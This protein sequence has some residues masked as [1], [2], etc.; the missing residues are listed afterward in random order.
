MPFNI[1]N[2]NGLRGLVYV[3][4]EYCWHIPGNG[5]GQIGQLKSMYRLCHKQ[6]E[7]KGT[8]TRVALIL[9]SMLPP[10][11]G[12]HYSRHCGGGEGYHQRYVSVYAGVGRTA[13][14]MCSA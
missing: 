8:K 3:C 4:N 14:P 11:M 9:Y 13:S 6:I 1:N 12:I 5:I 7:K 2:T 10:W